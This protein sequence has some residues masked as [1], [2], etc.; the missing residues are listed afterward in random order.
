MNR[1]VIGAIVEG[2]RVA[3][4]CR[5]QLRFIPKNHIF[6]TDLLDVFTVK[7]G[8]IVELVEFLDTALVKS[9]IA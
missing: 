9:V 8:K 2:D 6:T 3:V 5:V 4:H 7:D 1:D